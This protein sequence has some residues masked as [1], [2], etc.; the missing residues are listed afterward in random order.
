MKYHLIGLG[1]IGMSALAR[2]L[3]QKGEPVQGSDASESSLLTELTQEGVEVQLGHDAAHIQAGLSVVYSTDIKDTNPEIAKAKALKLPIF[4]R[5]DLLD[6]LMKGKK[7]ILVS[8]THG[9]T[10]TTALVASVLM[11]A[12]FDPSFAIGGILRSLSTNGRYGKGE[13]FVAEADESDGS[14]LKTKSEAAILTN[15]E[16][17]H[18]NYWETEEKLRDGFSQFCGQTRHL[19]WCADDSRLASMKLRGKS[20]GFSEKA[21]IRIIRFEQKG[22]T[23]S[24][25]LQIDKKT[26][27]AIT[28]PLLGAHNALNASAVF[29]LA[30]FIGVSEAAIREAFASF[31]GVK[32]RMEWRGTEKEVAVYDDYGHHPTEI[33]VTLKALKKAIGDRRLFVLF[34][35]HRYSRLLHLF[36]SFITCFDEADE[37]ILT[38]LYAARESP[39]PGVSSQ[40]LYVKLRERRGEH[41]HFFSR[42]ILER[43]SALLMQGGDVAL[44]I[45]AGDITHAAEEL[46]EC[47]REVL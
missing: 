30:L 19:F 10:T 37:L 33:A 13:Y 26:Y 36:D 27:P 12:K 25:D 22:W 20:Y 35:P 17:E 43:E 9:K 40:S 15:F 4:H 44:T 39:I 14:F 46:L 3:K 28:L 6:Q 2:I 41:V 1:G 24:F 31:G 5:S 47:L 29:A 8:G 42:R 38:D 16:P 34:Q 7:P 23:I 21:D 11:H 18:L 45:G 32:R